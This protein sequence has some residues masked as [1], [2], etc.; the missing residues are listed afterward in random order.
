MAMQNYGKKLVRSGKTVILNALTVIST[1]YAVIVYLI[2]AII[3]RVIKGLYCI[4]TD[5]PMDS[6]KLDKEGSSCSQVSIGAG[7]GLVLSGNKP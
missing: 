5:L 3:N 2:S 6:M 7:Y 1:L 4:S